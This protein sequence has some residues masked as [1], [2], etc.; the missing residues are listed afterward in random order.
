LLP[1]VG[2]EERSFR[3]RR[4]RAFRANN[5]FLIFIDKFFGTAIANYQP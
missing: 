1:D 2:Q 4:K 3:I 5:I